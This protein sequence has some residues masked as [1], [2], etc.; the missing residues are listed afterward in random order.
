MNRHITLGPDKKLT[1]FKLLARLE[2]SFRHLRL[3]FVMWDLRDTSRSR[4]AP[5]GLSP[6]SKPCRPLISVEHS[7]VLTPD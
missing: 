4:H 2:R 6:A 1:V 7:N 3:F 5:Q